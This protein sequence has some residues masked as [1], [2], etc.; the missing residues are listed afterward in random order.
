MI[1][2]SEYLKLQRHATAYQKLVGFLFKSVVRDPVED[3]VNDF[4]K[5]N[6]YTEGF[7]RDLK[8]GLQKSSL[9]KS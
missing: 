7:L 8:D 2:K 5:T 9:G 6:L 3:I 1:P 4:K